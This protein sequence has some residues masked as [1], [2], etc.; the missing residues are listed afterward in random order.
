MD[1]S[2]TLGAKPTRPPNILC[3][4]TDQQRFDHLGCTGNPDVKTPNI[5]KLAAEGV[6]FQNSFVANP[7]CMPAR[8]TLFTGRTPRGHGVRTNGIPLRRDIPI[9]PQILS[10]AGFLTHAAGKLHLTPW[11]ASAEREWSE[12]YVESPGYWKRHGLKEL[13]L[14]YYG[15][16]SVDS[17]VGHAFGQAGY[18]QWLEKNHPGK[19]AL[20]KRDKALDTPIEDIYKMALPEELH[21]NR[22]IADR[23]ISFLEKAKTEEKPFF[24]WCSFPDPHHPFAPPKP[25]CDMYD[26]EKIQFDPARAQDEFDRLPPFYRQLYDG[27]APGPTGM[28]AGIRGPTKRPDDVLRK[29]VAHTYG[30]ISFVDQ[31]IGRVMEQVDR[32][33]LREDTIIIFMSDHGD[34]MGDHWMI[35]KGPF[36]FNGLVKIPTIWSFPS[37][38]QKGVKT[39]ALASQIDFVPTLLDLCNVDFPEG[40]EPL[41]PLVTKECEHPALPG[42]SLA[43]V[44]CGEKEKVNDEVLI[45]NDE[46]YLALKVR[47]IVT[48]RYKLTLYGG[49]E[50][51]ELFD[52][53]TDPRELNNLWESPEHQQLKQQLVNQLLHAYLRQENVMPRR[54]MN[55]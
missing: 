29:M 15:F 5:D 23:S 20:M 47:S 53:E 42:K 19:S 21:Y 8:A 35:K 49:K 18:L 37:R 22:W 4:I 52:L 41:H 31:E 46:D 50:F 16:Q 26:P 39:A 9:L 12:N 25:W 30:L 34:M 2:T 54:T 32:L 40:E 11:N 28:V 51:G 13:P 55:A 1:S 7:L 14:P 27:G 17:V 38:F 48:G 44:L 6:L 24:L 36:H 10:N 43:P 45:E 33:G 3:F